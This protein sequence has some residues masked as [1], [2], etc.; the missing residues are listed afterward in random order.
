MN[1]SY[2]IL[3]G[4]ID[5]DLAEE[6]FPTLGQAQAVAAWLEDGEPFADFKVEEVDGEPTASADDFLPRPDAAGYPGPCPDGVT[7]EAWL[8]AT[9]VD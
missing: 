9:N 2:R 1:T 5:P 3:C 7:W 4:N 6:R 8:A